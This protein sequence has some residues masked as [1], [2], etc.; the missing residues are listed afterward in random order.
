MHRVST[1][2]CDLVHLHYHITL[3]CLN[4][5]LCKLNVTQTQKIEF[6]VIQNLSQCFYWQLMTIIAF[7]TLNG[8][9]IIYHLD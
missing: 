9:Q 5:I 6:R 2:F 8:A 7:Q 3:M 4:I 1:G